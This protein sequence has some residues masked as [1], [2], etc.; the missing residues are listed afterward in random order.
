[1]HSRELALG[2]GLAG[3]VLPG[4]LVLSQ[5]R[6]AKLAPPQHPAQRV[7]LG[8]ILHAEQCHRVKVGMAR[9]AR[10]PVVYS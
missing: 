9:N 6:G 3:Q 2:D 5:A 8:H 1:M 10:L 4:G 7:Q